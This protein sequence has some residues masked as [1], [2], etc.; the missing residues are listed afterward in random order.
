ERLAR[1]AVVQQIFN[2]ASTTDGARVDTSAATVSSAA[3]IVRLTRRI[4]DML[5]PLVDARL[6]YESEEGSSAPFTQPTAFTHGRSPACSWPTSMSLSRPPT[7]N[8]AFA[9][10][11][12]A[13]KDVLRREDLLHP[14]VA[15]ALRLHGQENMWSGNFE[16]ALSSLE[17]SLDIER[18]LRDGD[19]P[20]IAETQR[21]IGRQKME[22]GEQEEA[23]RH[24]EDALL[25]DRRLHNQG[26]HQT[27][28]ETL[29]LLGSSYRK[30]GQYEEALRYLNEAMEMEL[31]LEAQGLDLRVDIALTLRL[32]GIT[33][34][35]SYDVEA[36][37][38]KLTE[39]LEICQRHGRATTSEAPRSREPAPVAAIRLSSPDR[40][41]SEALKCL[42]E[43]LHWER[44]LH[45]N[46]DHP[47]L[48]GLLD[49][50]GSEMI[51]HGDEDAERE[52]VVYLEESLQMKR[53]LFG[54]RDCI[55]DSLCRIGAC[56]IQTGQLLEGEKSLDD[57][58]QMERRLHKEDHRDLAETLFLLGSMKLEELDRTEEG[59]SYIRESLQMVCRLHGPQGGSIA[60]QDH[61]ETARMLKVV[62]STMQAHGGAKFLAATSEEGERYLCEGKQ[63]EERLFE[64]IPEVEAGQQE[65]GLPKIAWSSYRPKS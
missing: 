41:M 60:S 45:S 17:E 64:E 4:E 36:A 38:P 27:I 42:K 58:L 8:R 3:W 2:A 63:M 62:G 15:A 16:E 55:V 53:R 13:S 33:L 1:E 50:L 7:P 48:A 25:M 22:D 18:N 23:Q 54:D 6:V 11:A 44:Q 35:E 9:V 20:A 28:A 40:L 56:Q 49:D 61:P 46:Q 34:L 52:G 65:T 37:L 26:D 59:L 29:R 10:E 39:S 47:D 14:E 30:V 21:L 12:E 5:F 51:D 31:R 32:M 19:H 57:A 24:L 43:L